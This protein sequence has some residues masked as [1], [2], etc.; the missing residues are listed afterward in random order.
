MKTEFIPYEQAKALKEIGF[1]ELCFGLYN[2]VK[3]LCY[4]NLNYLE[5][6]S[7]FDQNNQRDIV[8]APTYNQVYN[9]VRTIY[10]L[11]KNESFQ[12]CAKYYVLTITNISGG[13]LFYIANPNYNVANIRCLKELMEIIK[14][15]KY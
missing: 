3:E 6:K 2:P 4:P 8:K 10:N 14:N 7:F 12:S 5:W 15:E 9:W 1:D 11:H 13:E